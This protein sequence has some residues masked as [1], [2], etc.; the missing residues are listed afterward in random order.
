MNNTLEESIKRKNDPELGRRNVSPSEAPALI[1]RMKREPWNRRGVE[2]YFDGRTGMI[3]VNYYKHI[4]ENNR[5]PVVPIPEVYEG[6]HLNV[7]PFFYL[8]GG[9]VEYPV[10]DFLSINYNKL[11][12]IIGF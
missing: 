2:I 5:P 3:F 10:L 11:M 6:I 8:G 4:Y 7:G 1:R 12:D 9:R